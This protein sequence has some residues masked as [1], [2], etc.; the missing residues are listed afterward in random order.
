MRFAPC[1]STLIIRNGSF[2]VSVSFRNPCSA[3]NGPG[4]SLH[5]A[6]STKPAIAHADTPE[7]GREPAL[8]YPAAVGCVLTSG[9]KGAVTQQKM[10]VD[11]LR[12]L[13]G[14]NKT[15]HHLND[16]GGSFLAGNGSRTRKIGVIHKIPRDTLTCYNSRGYYER[17]RYILSDKSPNIPRHT[18]KRLHHGYTRVTPGGPS[19]RSTT[20][21]RS[22]KQPSRGAGI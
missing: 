18:R 22:A 10:H 4:D 8:A 19:W 6:T 2:A 14:K 21:A 12:A 15:P 20:S 9:F 3:W 16:D 7:K 5:P 1:A 13:T 11:L 17:D